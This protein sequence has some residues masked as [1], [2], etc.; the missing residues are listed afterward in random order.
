METTLIS[1]SQLL[2]PKKTLSEFGSELRNFDV[3]Y[4]VKRR[5]KISIQ[6]ENKS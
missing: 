6:R 4:M 5:E 3:V 1:M 2:D